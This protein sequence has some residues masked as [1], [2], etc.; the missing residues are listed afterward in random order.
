MTGIDKFNLEAL[1]NYESRVCLHRVVIW[2]LEITLDVH[3]VNTFKRQVFCRWNREVSCVF[4]MD[5]DVFRNWKA[6]NFDNFFITT[7]WL[8]RESVF[9]ARCHVLLQF[10]SATSHE[11]TD[12]VAHVGHDIG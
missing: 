7:V 6:C 11:I 1:L 8:L 12:C 2:L 5:D 4:V 3:S 9:G 10:S